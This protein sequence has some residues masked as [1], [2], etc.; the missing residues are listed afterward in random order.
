ME[1]AQNMERKT[2]DRE[3][4]QRL[5][6]RI[7]GSAVVGAEDYDCCW[8]NS[9]LMPHA[10]LT[11]L[12]HTLDSQWGRRWGGLFKANQLNSPEQHCE[13]PLLT[14]TLSNCRLF[15][16]FGVTRYLSCYEPNPAN[17]LCGSLFHLIDMFLTEV[18]LP[19]LEIGVPEWIY[20]IQQ[21]WS[22]PGLQTSR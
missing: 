8:K 13:H 2:Y 19:T 9:H 5:T 15:F 3:R 16:H 1:F 7:V 22:P 4:E 18:N 10:G 21:L 12:L 20:R 6:E 14:S 17:V 11:T